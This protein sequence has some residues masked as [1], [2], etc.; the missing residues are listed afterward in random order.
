[1]GARTT[2]F[3]NLRRHL[4][5]DYA[6]LSDQRIKATFRSRNVDAESMEG[7]LSDL[8]KFASSAGQAVLKAA[9]AVLP[10]AGRIVGTAFGGPA[11]GALGGS[12]G[13]LAGGAIGSATGQGAAA[14]QGLPMR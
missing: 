10:I 9:P 4:G 1:M 14:P 11:G 2:E 5:A 7:F 6:E 13:S 8:G 3:P 12:L